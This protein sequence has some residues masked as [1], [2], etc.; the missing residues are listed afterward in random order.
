MLMPKS[1]IAGAA[2]ALTAAAA[3]LGLGAGT[4]GATDWPPLQN[5]A[6]LYSGPTGSGAVTKVDLGDAGTCHT[7]SSPAVSVQVVSGSWALELYSG[8]GCTSRHP[9]RT[10][11]LDQENL[12]WN[13]LSYRVVPA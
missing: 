11:S 8:A 12:P 10:G 6:Y 3:L 7:L 5:G 9:W 4:A 1:K 2:A 13:M